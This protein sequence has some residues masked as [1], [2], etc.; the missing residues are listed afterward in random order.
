MVSPWSVA[1]KVLW[2]HSSPA[3]ELP[4]ETDVNVADGRGRKVAVGGGVF[5]I[6]GVGGGGVAVGIT[7]WVSATIV[8]AS[9]TTV[10]WM[11]SGLSVGAA[12]APQPLTIRVVMSTKLRIAK[13]FIV[14]ISL[15][16]NPLNH[17]S[18]L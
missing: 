10:F 8:K 11:S 18:E 5:V 9:A 16:P 13:H 12:W 17:T 2:I 14:N 6:V 3:P 15:L 1:G 7:A 4:L